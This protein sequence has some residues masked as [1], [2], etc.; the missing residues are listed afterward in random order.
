MTLPFSS[1]I[2]RGF[3]FLHDEICLKSGAAIAGIRSNI[4]ST[5][6]DEK[7]IKGT[8]LVNTMR[9]N[10]IATILDESTFNKTGMCDSFNI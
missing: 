7:S 9:R 8:V 2:E 3:E 1:P 6:Q 10:V 5:F 4:K